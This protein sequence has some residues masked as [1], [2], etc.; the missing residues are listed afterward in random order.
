MK[1]CKKAF[2]NVN[3]TSGHFMFAHKVLQERYFSVAYVKRIFFHVNS[4]IRA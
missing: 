1:I 3:C 2:H 4:Y